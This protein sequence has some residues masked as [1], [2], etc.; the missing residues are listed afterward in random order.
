MRP[1]FTRFFRFIEDHV[2]RPF[3]GIESQS[4]RLHRFGEF[5]HVGPRVLLGAGLKTVQN[6]LDVLVFAVLRRSLRP[7]GGRRG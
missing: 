1:Q 5:K 4:L 2:R 7:A 3:N 6:G